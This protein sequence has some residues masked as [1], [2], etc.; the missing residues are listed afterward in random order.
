MKL[1]VKLT[2]DGMIR[3]LRTKAHR[4]AD[5]RGVRVVRSQCG[6]S[7]ASAKPESAAAKRRER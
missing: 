4:Q 6:N 2:L 1:A 3:A 7:A 5:A